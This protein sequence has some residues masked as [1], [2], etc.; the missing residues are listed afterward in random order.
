MGNTDGTWEQDSVAVLKEDAAKAGI[1]IKINVMP[2][3]QYWDVWTKAPFSLTSWAHRP[4]GVMTL[5][6]AYRSGVPWNETSYNNPAFDAALD[7]AEAILDV[8][9]RRAK[10]EKVEKILQDDAILVQPF[11]RANITAVRD[12]VVG[13]EMHPAS[14]YKFHKVSLA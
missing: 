8:E 11:F 6:L 7:E 13:F 10:M 5:S 4:L 14:Y 2:P 1:D 9:K 12:N 3:A